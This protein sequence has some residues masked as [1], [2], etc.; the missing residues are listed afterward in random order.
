[1]D[2]ADVFEVRGMRRARRGVAQR[3]V[4]APNEVVLTYTG[5]DRVVRTT[6][7]R[8]DPAP[9]KIDERSASYR[10]TLPPGEATALFVALRCNPRTP[11]PVP[12]L[13]GLHRA[14]REARNAARDRA[15]VETSNPLF[16]EVVCRSMADLAMLI[17][18]TVHGPYPY[19]GIP[20]YSTTFGRDGLITAMQMLWVDPGM[21]RGVLSR[22]AALQAKTVDPKRDAE[23]GKILHEMRAG[24]MA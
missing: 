24:E 19:A 12:F 9:A 2:F 23:P 3:K 22:L 13:R 14:H 10:I 15:A 4:T 20:W 17:T 7:I 18:D 11:E 5:L 8:L 1:S 21:A 16:N 6:A